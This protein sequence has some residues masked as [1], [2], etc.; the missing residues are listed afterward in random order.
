VR[1]GRVEL[2]APQPPEPAPAAPPAPPAR[3]PFADR[4]LARRYLDRTLD[5]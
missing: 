5:R 3:A 2:R 4:A 1:I